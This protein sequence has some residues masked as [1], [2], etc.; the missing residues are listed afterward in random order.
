MANRDLMIQKALVDDLLIATRNEEIP[1]DNRTP[2]QRKKDW[3]NNQKIDREAIKQ[4]RDSEKLDWDQLTPA[5]QEA[6]QQAL[7]TIRR[8]D[9]SQEEI[10]EGLQKEDMKEGNFL[11]DPENLRNMMKILNQGMTTYKMMQQVPF[12]VLVEMLKIG[13][14]GLGINAY[15]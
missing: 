7:D 13:G 1:K 9:V 10:N 15:R 12:K 4:R 5:E 6:R 14:A 8:G 3:L 2:R 11:Q